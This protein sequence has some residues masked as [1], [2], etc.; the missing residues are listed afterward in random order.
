MCGWGSGTE[1]KGHLFAWV[2]LAQSIPSGL[3]T[4][5]EDSDLAN[6]LANEVYDN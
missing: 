3:I 1:S 2:S 6:D 5:I 4:P